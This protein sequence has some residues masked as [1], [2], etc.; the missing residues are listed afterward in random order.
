MEKLNREQIRA[1]IK[2]C[3]EKIEQLEAELADLVKRDYLLSDEVQWYKEEL[4]TTGR[5]K[6]KRTFLEG[7]VYWNQFFKD[8]DTGEEI[9]I[10]RSQQI[11]VDGVW[12]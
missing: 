2:A 8:E 1:E 9:K 5:G 11:T 12:I 10:E 6:K 3:T 7:R 4:R